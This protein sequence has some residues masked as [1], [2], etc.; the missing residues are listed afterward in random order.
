M[1][2]NKKSESEKLAGKLNFSIEVTA[3][4][5]I[6]GIL[7]LTLGAFGHFMSI[8]IILAWIADRAGLLKKK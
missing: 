5:F 8:I 3:L 1:A 7:S 6:C 2:K 4:I